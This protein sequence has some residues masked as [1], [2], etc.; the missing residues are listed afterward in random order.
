MTLG[1]LIFVLAGDAEVKIGDQEANI[2]LQAAEPNVSLAQELHLLVNRS[3][4]GCWIL[5]AHM[6]AAGNY[7]EAKE[8]KSVDSRQIIRFWFEEVDSSQWYK[9]DDAFDELLRR[10]F[11]TVHEAASKAELYWWR[12]TATGRL[13]EIIVLDQFSRN[14]FRDQP[15]SF[16][17]DA[18]A[19]CLAQE[20][21]AAGADKG[22]T[23]QQQPF[24]YMPYMHSE[25]VEIHEVALTLF[26]RLKT[27][28]NL[29]YEMRHKAI[30][31]RFGRYPHRNELLNRPSTP[32]EIEFL[33]EPGSTF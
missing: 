24:M 4:N 5:G 25:S 2:G 7:D 6:L 16:A 23:E 27:G 10:R 31:D 21:I 33:K 20:A 14:I 28:N 26:A 32:E 1:N 29:E 8:M 13:A 15:Q 30:I 9:K 3:K 19:L 11:F 17:H 12:N 22:L 18:M